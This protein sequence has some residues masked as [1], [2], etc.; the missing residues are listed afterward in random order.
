MKLFEAANYNFN[1][2]FFS[3]LIDIKSRSLLLLA[4]YLKLPKTHRSMLGNNFSQFFSKKSRLPV[5]TDL[6]SKNTDA[7]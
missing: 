7:Q 3:F 4:F 2:F 6:L 5:D 1:H